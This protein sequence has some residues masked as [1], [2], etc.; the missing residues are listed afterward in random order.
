[1]LSRIF[2]I[3]ETQNKNLTKAG[4]WLCPG[5]CLLPCKK[6]NAIWT[7]TLIMIIK[8]SEH[9]KV[10]SANPADWNSFEKSTET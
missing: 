4:M 5:P 3:I 10:F 9:A 1:M 6:K 2:V 8:A 7:N